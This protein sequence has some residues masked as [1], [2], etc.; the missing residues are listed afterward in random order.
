LCPQSGDP[1]RRA[2]I[3]QPSS[4]QSEKRGLTVRREPVGGERHEVWQRL[5]EIVE[6]P[7]HLNARAASAGGEAAQHNRP[8]QGHRVVKAAQRQRGDKL[9]RALKEIDLVVG[10]DLLEAQQA[11]ALLGEDGALRSHS[12]TFNRKRSS[13]KSENAAKMLE[14][15]ED[16]ADPGRPDAGA[17]TA[18]GGD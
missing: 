11:Q 10:R 17:R 12:A 15:S 13:G 8:H 6:W 5:D 14:C 7:H 1:R 9:D 2:T 18:R 4:T 16:C 3:T